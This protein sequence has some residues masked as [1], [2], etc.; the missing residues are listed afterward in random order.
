MTLK[1][2]LTIALQ[3]AA[4]LLAGGAADAESITRQAKD[5]ITPVELNKG[6]TLRFQLRNGQVRTVTLQETSAKYLLTNVQAVKKPQADGAGVYWFAAKVLIDGH[7]ITLERFVGSQETFYEP[8]VINGMRVWLDGVQDI[9]DFLTENH[10]ACKPKK[11][12]RLAV[13]DATDRICPVELQLWFPNEALFIDVGET[14]NGDNA[15]MGAHKGAD[16][17]GGLDINRPKGSPAYSP[18]DFDDHYL[19]NSLAR[20]D[21][22]NRWRGI[23]K[24]PNGDTWVLQNH[25]MFDLVVPEHAPLKAGMLYATNAGTHLGAQQHAHFNFKVATQEDGAEV[26]LDP[27]IF[28]WQTFEDAK[29]RANALK[30]RFAPVGPAAAGK[31]VTFDARASRQGHRGRPLDC[32]WSFGDGNFS[33]GDVAAHAFANPGI[34]AVTLTVFDGAE[35]SSMTQ[36]LTV[37]GVKAAQPALALRAPGIPAFRPRPLAATDVYG[38]VV[39]EVPH[40]LRFVARPRRPAPALQRIGIVNI[41][42]GVLPPL[43]AVVNYRRNDGWLKARMANHGNDQTLE[44][45]VDAKALEPG[46]Y[47]ALVTVQAPG[48]LN[49]HAQFPVQLRIPIGMPNNY[50]HGEDQLVIVD[51]EDAGCYRTPWFWISPRFKNWKP[52]GYKGSYLANGARDTAGEFVRFTPDLAAGNHEV[53][54]SPE[55]PFPPGARFQVRIRHRRVEELVWVEPAK[56]LK[57]GYFDFAEGMDGSIDF[58]SDGAPGQVIADVVIFRRMPATWVNESSLSIP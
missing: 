8:Y 45:S 11:H 34:Y 47:D 7:P 55:T 25:H 6:D 53:M 38:A 29:K 17:H 19:L 28:F 30:A 4:L 57:I 51:N 23:R 9:F 46:Y 1:H 27:W 43:E 31:P 20:G 18:M 21:N 49:G 40:L 3:T 58:L 56:S 52:K 26:L 36:H 22:N 54:L 15:W 32:F 14:Y 44:I 5:T 41:G 33:T 35:Y 37:D 13:N 2:S 42:S 12:A 50:E 48:M 10:G 39:R 24:W 16:A